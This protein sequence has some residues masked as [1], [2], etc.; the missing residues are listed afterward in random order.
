VVLALLIPLLAARPASAT[1]SGGETFHGVIVT[2]GLSGSRVVISTAIVATG[3][4]RGAGRIVEVENLPTDPDNVSRDDLVFAGGSMHLV[5]TTVDSNFQPDL[6]SCR[7]VATLDQV[8]EIT[9]GTGRFANASGS[10]TATVTAR[11]RLAREADGSCSF[12]RVPLGEVDIVVSNG[13]L[14]L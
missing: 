14:S 11:G 12:E 13:T 1:T 8:G 5:S 4:F 9:G 3:V 10:S 2:S 7:F 6:T